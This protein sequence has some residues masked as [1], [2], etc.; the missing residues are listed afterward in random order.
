M[1][2]RMNV[3]ELY[4]VIKNFDYFNQN[5]INSTVFWS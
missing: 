2:V 1:K 4:A 3:N 5:F